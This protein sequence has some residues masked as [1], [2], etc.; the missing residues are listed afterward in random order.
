MEPA[1]EGFLTIPLRFARGR[2]LTIYAEVGNVHATAIID[3]GGQATIGNLALRDALLSKRRHTEL[4]TS[5]V[6]S[7]TTNATQ[8]G[9]GYAAPTISLGR[10]EIRSAHVT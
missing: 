8:P 6:V 4:P 7:D 2:V 3:T 10:I 5:D 1:R 9:E